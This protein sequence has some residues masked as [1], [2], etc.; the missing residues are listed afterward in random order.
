MY[1]MISLS[2]MLLIISS[3]LFEAFMIIPQKILISPDNLW[4]TYIINAIYGI[5]T[6]V[7][8]G[9]AIAYYEY[10]QQIY[11]DL[12][13]YIKQSKECTHVLMQMLTE[14]N[15]SLC[16]F[17]ISQY[18]NSVNGTFIIRKLRK[19]NAE[20]LSTI[21]NIKQYMQAV[22]FEINQIN[23]YANTV[24]LL[25][26]QLNEIS[27]EFLTA[28]CNSETREN[29]STDIDESLRQKNDLDKKIILT[30]EHIQICSERCNDK[31]KELE[32]L[33]LQLY[34]LV[35]SCRNIFVI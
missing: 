30:E 18:N 16:L 5:F 22:N 1:F 33:Y 35:N 24:N 27:T 20:I 6:G 26:K 23:S 2:C 8:T 34:N 14:K 15:Y 29:L 7:L 10:R 28:L 32:N 25:K 3:Y 17:Q 21:E 4:F 12:Y 11:F 9:L 19:N 13:N 31:L